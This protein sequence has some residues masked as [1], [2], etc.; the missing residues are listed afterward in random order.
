MKSDVVFS[1]KSDDW[2]TPVGFYRQR[3]ECGFF[4][5]CPL[6]AGFDGLDLDWSD[7]EFLFC[8]PPYSN[9]S[10]FVEKAIKDH[11]K[12]QEKYQHFSHWE[13]LLPVRT[14]TKWFARLVE[15][16]VDIE[17]ITGRVKFGQCKTGAPF[18]SMLVTLNGA[19]LFETFV[20]C[21]DQEGWWYK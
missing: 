4:D 11:K 3:M 9:I 20:R 15:Y 2:F 8:N 19:M 1:H 18:P 21:L 5:P 7:H 14:D 13:L 16:G 6:R 12:Y 17:F 10:A